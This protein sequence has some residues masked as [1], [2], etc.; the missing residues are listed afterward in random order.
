VSGAT[1]KLLKRNMFRV[2]LNG[3]IITVL[4]AVVSSACTQRGG[5]FTQ[6]GVSQRLGREPKATVRH[7]MS[8]ELRP[9]L[10]ET[11]R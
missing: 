6:A 7:K 2:V 8:D 9:R 3:L 5:G 4:S 1:S 10:R 11:A